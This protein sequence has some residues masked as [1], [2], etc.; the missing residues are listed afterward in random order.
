MEDEAEAEGAESI[1][2]LNSVEATGD[3]DR[4]WI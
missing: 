1:T 4:G 2:G 3:V